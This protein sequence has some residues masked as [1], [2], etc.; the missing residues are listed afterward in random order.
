MKYTVIL[1]SPNSI[2]SE[3]WK[4]WCQKNECKLIISSYEEFHS[5]Y[6]TIDT[7]V[8]LVSKQCIPNWGFKNIDNIFEHEISAVIDNENLGLVM[9]QLSSL[10][11]ELKNIK[12]QLNEHISGDI[13]FIHNKHL[14][15]ISDAINTSQCKQ[16]NNTILSVILK[17]LGININILDIRYNILNL[18]KNDW[19]SYNWQLKVD[20]TPF[21][22]KYGHIWNFNNMNPSEQES[23]MNQLYNQIHIHN[24]YD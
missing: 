23:F 12:L 2:T 7:H 1:F 9:S 17:K 5:L 24:L 8:L 4:K 18:I 19:L 21:F 3:I 15:I 16:L 13:L 11:S 20:Q 10:P 6:P 14:N 22:I